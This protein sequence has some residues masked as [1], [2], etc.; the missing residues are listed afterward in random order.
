MTESVARKIFDDLLNIEVNIIVKPAMTARKMPGPPHALLD[1]I[2]EYD[3]YL[4]RLAATL[5]TKWNGAPPGPPIRVRGPLV[6][7]ADKRS[8]WRTDDG[9]MLTVALQAEAVPSVVSVDTF[10]KLRERAVETECVLRDPSTQGADV[11]DADAMILRRIYR[12]CDQIKQILARD[13]VAA[14]IP[15]GGLDR[16]KSSGIELPLTADEVLTVRKVWDVGVELVVMQTVAQLDGDIITRIQRA[17]VAST[18]A[19][20]HTLHREAV[21]SALGHWQSMFQT[22]VQFTTSAFQSL[23]SR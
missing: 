19:T 17:R 4:T 11:D 18:N 7:G 23:V 12:N 3:Q 5:T 14:A 2:G 13:E 1:I 9:G 21:D 8:V 20:L 10:D 22:V 6:V 15:E 16:D